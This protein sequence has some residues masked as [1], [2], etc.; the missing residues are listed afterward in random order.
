MPRSRVLPLARRRRPPSSG[1][2]R[3]PRR[4]AIVAYPD[5]PPLD[6]TGPLEVFA[7]AARFLGAP[8]PAY[9]VEILTSGP[10][11]LVSSSGVRLIPDGRTVGSPG[12]IDT[13]MVAGGPG[14]AAAVGNRALVGWLRR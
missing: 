4:V 5:F 6:V 7:Q 8:P 13:L 14:V 3:E 1:A 2:G 12:R 10:R 11:P 9:A